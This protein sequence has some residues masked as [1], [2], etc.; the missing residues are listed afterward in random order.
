MINIR[1]T[2]EIIKHILVNLLI[3]KSE[4]IKSNSSIKLKDDPFLLKEKIRI[5]IDEG[6][7]RGYVYGCQSTISDKEIKIITGD[8]ATRK[9]ILEYCLIIHLQDAPMYGLY[10]VIGD[11][12]T[13]SDPLISTSLD[14]KSWMPCN[15]YLQAT[16]L[17]GMEQLRDYSFNWTK[18]KDYDYEFEGMMSFLQ[19]YNDFYGGD[20]EGQ[21]S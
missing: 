12:D 17:A 6:I 13:P 15:T 8:C 10:L 19:H 14:G 16:F 1:L 3:I 21:E 5:E 7:M 9:D 2:E 4:F 11:N 20:H 18:A